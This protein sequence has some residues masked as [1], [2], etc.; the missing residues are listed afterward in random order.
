MA[1]QAGEDFLLKHGDDTVIAG[2]RSTGMTLNN[3]AVDVTTKDS[4]GMRTLLA[5]AGIQSWTFSASGV[6]TDAASEETLRSQAAAG[7]LDTYKIVAGNGDSWSASFLVTSYARNG[8]YNGEENFDITLE[9]S[10][11]ITYAAA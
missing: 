6:F 8:E 4:A 3:E 2:L 5:G 9:S 7:S 10:G 1:A 11:A